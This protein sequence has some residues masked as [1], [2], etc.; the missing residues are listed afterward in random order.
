MIDQSHLSRVLELAQQSR[1]LG[2]HPFG[3]LLVVDGVVAAEAHNSVVTDSDLTA[4]AEMMLVRGLETRGELS[5]LAN[6]TVY[7][8]CEPCPMCVGA[9]FWAGARSV[10]FGL[11]HDRL[12]EIVRTPF[13]EAF[14]FTISA[15]DIGARSQPP[16]V[17]DGPHR[18]D[19]A[20]R[21]HRGF[22]HVDD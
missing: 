10:V 22:W 11:S 6:G 5:Q 12:N 8:S 18:E 15:H 17:F 3:A 14:G 20:A 1:Q 13:E 4:H 9:L 2:N 21:A 19:D 7:A 16:L